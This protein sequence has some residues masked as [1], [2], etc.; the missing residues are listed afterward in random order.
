MVN[1]L[2]SAATLLAI[3]HAAPSGSGSS[4]SSSVQKNQVLA[5]F[6]DLTAVPGASELSPI[7]TYKGLNYN[8]FDVL[9]A[10]VA[11]LATG[12]T[13]QSSPNTAVNALTNDLTTGGPSLTTATVKAFDLQYLYFGCVAMSLETVAS[14]PLECTVAFTAY[15]VGSD[16]PFATVN[17]QFNPTNAVISKMSKAD[18]G[19]QYLSEFSGLDR[20]DISVVQ[21]AGTSTLTALLID[22]VAYATYNY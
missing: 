1:V 21:S 20:V 19:G 8:S 12:V 3:A 16:V 10:G 5:T 6:D 7:N 11:G 15:K 4:S 18:F 22:N 9:Q 13:P 14:V 17:Q 2:L